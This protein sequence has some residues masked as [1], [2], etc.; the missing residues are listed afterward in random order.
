[1]RKPLDVAATSS[2]AERMKN[3]SYRYATDSETGTIQAASLDAAYA[4]LR[5]KITDAMIED[6]AAMWVEGDDEGRLT[7]GVDRD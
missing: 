6:G 3:K 5:G 1:M 7:M 2:Y 4:A